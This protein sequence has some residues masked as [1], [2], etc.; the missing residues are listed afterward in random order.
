[1]RVCLNVCVCVRV[2]LCI[3]MT[4]LTT[5]SSAV[6]KYGMAARQSKHQNQVNI[7]IA[8]AITT[9]IIAVTEPN[10]RRPGIRKGRAT[11]CDYS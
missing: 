10:T 8:T 1:M 6:I 4:S 5:L 9:A 7:S 3:S 2:Q 11:A